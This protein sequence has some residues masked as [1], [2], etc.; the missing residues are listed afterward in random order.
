MKTIHFSL[1]AI[2]TRSAAG[3]AAPRSRPSV[4]RQIS[5]KTVPNILQNDAVV[6]NLSRNTPAMPMVASAATHKLSGF[7]MPGSFSA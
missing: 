3:F 4:Q 1:N 7:F 5:R 2:S 6:H